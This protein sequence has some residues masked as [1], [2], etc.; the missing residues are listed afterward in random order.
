M[1]VPLPACRAIRSFDSSPPAFYPSSSSPFRG[2]GRP[3]W[4]EKGVGTAACYQR[5]Y[6]LFY[7]R[8]AVPDISMR[9]L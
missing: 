8:F 2:G 3:G 5:R 4:R 6:I 7:A 9:Q 1:A